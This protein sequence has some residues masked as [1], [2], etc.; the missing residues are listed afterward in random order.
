MLGLFQ[1]KW[2]IFFLASINQRKVCLVL[3]RLLLKSRFCKSVNDYYFIYI[4]TKLLSSPAWTLCLG[5]TRLNSKPGEEFFIWW[6]EVYWAIMGVGS[7]KNYVYFHL[8]DASFFFTTSL[9]VYATVL[10]LW[11]DRCKLHRK[12]HSTANCTA[13]QTAQ[14]RVLGLDA[15]HCDHQSDSAAARLSGW[16]IVRQAHQKTSSV[17]TTHTNSSTTNAFSCLYP[18]D[19]SFIVETGIFAY[20]PQQYN[21]LLFGTLI[22]FVILCICFSKMQI[23]ESWFE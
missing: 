15:V 19:I 1:P 11:S 17:S 23:I 14:R 6:K 5:F 2:F 9:T 13:P 12:L 20:S 18:V 22:L 7:T 4:K 10:S 21:L 3:L 8:I 16:S